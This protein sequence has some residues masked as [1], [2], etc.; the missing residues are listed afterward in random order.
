MHGVT[1]KIEGTLFTISMP[2]QNLLYRK[3]E[4]LRNTLSSQYL[5]FTLILFKAVFEN[6]LGYLQG[7]SLIK[8][9]VL[10][11][12]LQS[13]TSLTHTS[14]W[15]YTHC[16]NHNSVLMLL[17]KR[18]TWTACGEQKLCNHFLYHV[19]SEQTEFRIPLQPSGSEFFVS[20]CWLRMKILNIYNFACFLPAV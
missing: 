6:F 16:T 3:L 8:L 9:S 10:T 4:S 7:I 17:A 2:A 15:T 13:K 14:T 12:D 11:K 1:T 19:T 18:S 20:I 5:I